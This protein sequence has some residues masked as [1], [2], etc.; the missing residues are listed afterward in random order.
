MIR[1]AIRVIFDTKS[2]NIYRHIQGVEHAD[3]SK[4]MSN[5]PPR[6]YIYYSRDAV[7]L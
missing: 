5:S 7:R 6:D 2:V 3:L 1:L 4:F